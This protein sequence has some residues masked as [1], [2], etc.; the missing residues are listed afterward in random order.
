M[1][2]NSRREGE[3]TEPVVGHGHNLKKKGFPLNIRIHLLGE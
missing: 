1:Y 3:K 2:I